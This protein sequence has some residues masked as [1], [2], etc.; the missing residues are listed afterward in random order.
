MTVVDIFTLSET[1]INTMDRKR[2][3]GISNQE[4]NS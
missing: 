2:R 4:G 1:D 3:D